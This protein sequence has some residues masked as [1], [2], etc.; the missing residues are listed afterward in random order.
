MA[1]EKVD[2]MFSRKLSALGPKHVG[3]GAK[4]NFRGFHHRFRKRGMGMDGHRYIAGQRGHL[5]G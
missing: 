4:E 5:D 3:A 2:M 1:L